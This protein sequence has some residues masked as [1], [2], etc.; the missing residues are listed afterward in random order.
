MTINPIY[1]MKSSSYN[2]A[3]ISSDLNRGDD[4]PTHLVQRPVEWRREAVGICVAGVAAQR[5]RPST[6]QDAWRAAT[7]LSGL[8]SRVRRCDSDPRLQC[9]LSIASRAIAPCPGGETGRRKGLKIPRR[10]PCRFE[11]GPGHTS[12]ILAA[13]HCIGPR[14]GCSPIDARRNEKPRR[15]GYSDVQSEDRFDDSSR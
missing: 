9:L 5:P 2:G 12:K 7:I 13:G 3:H 6:W 1:L 15:A 11:S 14:R 10:E 8:Q 4:R